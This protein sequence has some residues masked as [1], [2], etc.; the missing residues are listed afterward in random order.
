[1]VVPVPKKPRTGPCIPDDSR[2]IALTS[3]VYKA[4]C[5]VIKERVV[6]VA[7]ERGWCQRSNVDSGR[8][9]DAGISC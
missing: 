2:G 3:V 4:M 5:I 8:G 1:M 6:K 7:E 9:E